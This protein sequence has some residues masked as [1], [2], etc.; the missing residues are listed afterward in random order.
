M[1]INRSR[2]IQTFQLIPLLVV[3]SITS[4][5]SQFA[6]QGMNVDGVRKYKKGNY[7][8]ASQRF[9]KAIAE[10]AKSPD[11]Y[12]N[13]AAVTHEA[14][15][16][17]KRE[18]DFRQAEEL[19]HQ[20]LNYDPDHV[21]CHRALA[22]L[23]TDTNRTDAAFRL[24]QGWKERSPALADPR[25]ELAQLLEETG[26]IAAAKGQLEE[27]LSKD[28]FNSRALASLGKIQDQAGEY[29]QALNNYQRSLDLNGKQSV[30][31]ERL[32]KLQATLSATNPA[33]APKQQTRMVRQPTNS[34]R[35]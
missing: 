4:G 31:R 32:A 11:G 24:L 15:R 25:I 34:I 20:C 29:T 2:T 1:A 9:R 13:L 21:E 19:Y 23:L 22:V 12:Y 5:C 28:P 16:I 26:N 18:S 17:S 10:N 3:L 7:Q 33:L 35:Y 14:A 8:G 30:V 6:S 27:A